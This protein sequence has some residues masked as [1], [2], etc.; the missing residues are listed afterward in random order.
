LIEEES[1]LNETLPILNHGIT[2]LPKSACH[3]WWIVCG[4]SISPAM[5]KKTLK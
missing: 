4:F 3:T 2:A 1:S 5:Q